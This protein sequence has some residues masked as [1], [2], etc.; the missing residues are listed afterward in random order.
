M[1]LR[2]F[3]LTIH[4]SIGIFIG[5]LLVVMGLTGSLLVFHETVEH[6]TN[7]AVMEVVPE[8]E[9]LPIDTL[10]ESL[11]ASLPGDRLRSITIPKAADEPYVFW[12]SSEEEQSSSLYVNPYTGAVLGSWNFDRTVTGFLLRLHYTFLAGTP[13][14][15][16]A[17]TCGVLMMVLGIT[18]IILWPG[19]KN[20][21]AGFKLRWGSAKQLLSYDLHKVTGVFFSLVLVLLGFTGTVIVLLHHVEPLL[22]LIIGAPP[23]KAELPALPANPKPLSFGELLQ[24]TEETLPGGKAISISFS[25]EDKREVQV[26]LAFPEDPIPDIPL[27]NVS[28]DRFTGKVLSQQKTVQWT[29]GLRL[30]QFLL[31]FHFGRFWGVTSQV[32]YAIAG[33]TPTLFLVTGFVLWQKRRWQK[34]RKQ[35]AQQQEVRSKSLK[36]V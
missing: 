25:G 12:L 23:E 31:N 4:G 29:P 13:G 34:A 8:G 35:E 36:Q 28:L 6:A 20:L 7:P 26:R 3:V 1:K 19:W 14:E 17:G 5:L 2:Q 16:L 30:G 22:A 18:G 33:L 10:M 27:S 9:M 24:R 11:Q 32:I 15:F 21:K